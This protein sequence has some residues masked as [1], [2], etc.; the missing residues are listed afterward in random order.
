MSVVFARE[1]CKGCGLCIR[2]CP[3]G[4]IVPDDR[5][6]TSGFH[7]A[8]VVEIDKCTA[9]AICAMMCPDLVIQVWKETG[10]EGAVLG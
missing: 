2:F 8:T 6:N 5:I 1:R 3:K 9:C 10:E 4:I 7:P